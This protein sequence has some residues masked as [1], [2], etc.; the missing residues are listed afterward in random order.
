MLQAACCSEGLQPSGCPNRGLSDSV[1]SSELADSLRQCRPHGVYGT[2]WG[3]PFVEPH[4]AVLDGKDPPAGGVQGDLLQRP[5]GHIQVLH[6]PT[7]PGAATLLDEA[8]GELLGKVPRVLE[9]ESSSSTGHR[10][11]AADRHM[12]QLRQSIRRAH[13]P[14]LIG[15]GIGRVHAGALVGDLDLRG[16]SVWSPVSQLPAACSPR[17][18]GCR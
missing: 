3:G 6:V 18:P 16:T 2:A 8:L 9:T 15:D 4:L 5:L 11:S 10:R 17:C 13:P 1:E 12:A 7:A 14:A